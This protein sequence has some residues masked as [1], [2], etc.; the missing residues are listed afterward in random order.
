MAEEFTIDPLVE[1]HIVTVIEFHLD[2]ERYEYGSRRIIPYEIK[3]IMKLKRNALKCFWKI[4]VKLLW[5]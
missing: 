2:W 4:A 5:L 1:L 3:K